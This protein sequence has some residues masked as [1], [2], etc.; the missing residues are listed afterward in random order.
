MSAPFQP[1]NP[2][3]LGHFRQAAMTTAPPFLSNDV[4]ARYLYAL[5]IQLDAVAEYFRIGQL[6]SFPSYCEEEA[7]PHLG[8]DLLLPRGPIEPVPSY[9]ER[10]RLAPQTWKRAGNPKELL[11]QLAAYFAPS[12]PV[13]RYVAN[14]YAPDGSTIADWWTL[15]G[16]VYTYHRA[17]PSNWNWDGVSGGYRFWII[18]YLP[19]LSTPVWDD[20]TLSWNKPGLLWDFDGGA[21]VADVRAIVDKWKC[22]GTHME[23]LIIA[24]DTTTRY[25]AW[26]DPGVD[27]GDPGL[28]WGMAAGTVGMFDPTLPAGPPMPSGNWQDAANRDPNAQYLVGL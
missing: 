11:G 17:S 13:I 8:K 14:G 5:G 27:W 18:L 4:G 25:L 20:P 26:G 3:G 12:P 6:Q 24:S 2:E 15:S 23:N 19:L 16:G 9:R 10:L 28:T 7:L 1:I 21:Y 22:A